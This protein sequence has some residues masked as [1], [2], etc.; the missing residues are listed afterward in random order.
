M[1]SSFSALYAYSKYAL[2]V[3]YIICRYTQQD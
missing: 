1:K 3:G 2:A